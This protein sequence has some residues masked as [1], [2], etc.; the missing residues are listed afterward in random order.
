MIFFDLTA[1]FLEMNG[2]R[3]Q[4]KRCRTELK[5]VSWEQWDRYD[6]S[7]ASQRNLD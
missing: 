5:N 2:K 6:Y 4:I 3:K 7:I 1:S